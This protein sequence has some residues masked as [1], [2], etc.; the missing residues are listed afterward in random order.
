MKYFIYLIIA[1]PGIVNAQTL[2]KSIKANEGGVTDILYLK[3]KNQIISAGNDNRFHVWDFSSNTKIKSLAGHSK[4]TLVN[5][6]GDFLYTSGDSKVIQWNLKS[7]KPRKILNHGTE[8]S[9]MLIN[10]SNLSV[11][12]VGSNKAIVWNEEGKQITQLEINNNYSGFTYTSNSQNI[13]FYDGQSLVQMNVLSKVQKQIYSSSAPIIGVAEFNETYGI[14][15]AAKEVIFWSYSSEKIKIETEGNPEIIKF[16]PDGQYLFVGDDI[17]IMYIISVAEGILLNSMGV[18]SGA[19]TSIAF[20]ENN[21]IT[22]SLDAYIKI[23]DISFLN[24]LTKQPVAS[25]NTGPPPSIEVIQPKIIKANDVIDIDEPEYVIKGKVK[26]E[27]GIFLLLVRGFEVPINPDG[28][29]SHK[30][31]LHYFENDITVKAL[32]NNKNATEMSFIL[33]RPFK[34]ETRQYARRGSDY[35]LIIA[36]NDYDEITDLTN[37]IFDAGVI[38]DELTKNY[39]FNV[40]TLLNPTQI[41]LYTALRAYNKKIFSEHDQLFIFIAGHGEYDDVFQE[42]YLVTKDSRKSDDV[43]STYISHSNLRTIINNINCEHILLVMDVCFGGTFD[44]II[45]RRGGDDYNAIDKDE[46]IHRKLQYKTRLYVTSGGKEYVPDGR[47]GAHS[48]FARKFIEAL[49]NY[50]GSDQILTLNELSSYVEKVTPEPRKGEFGDN[51]PGSDFLF[52]KK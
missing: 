17:G 35:A 47:P 9:A 1:L 28:T 30:M 51:E 15:T 50:G 7:L 29:F 23:H 43:K 46:F 3:E 12:T 33:N 19:I 11:L 24:I 20:D 27:S 48:P 44:P 5:K 10:N 52:I 6:V 4:S 14:T 31:K 8:I 32:D 38:A 41:E 42:G 2:K 45:A 37:P 21:L 16:S 25:V 34:G 18:H 22:S 13:L 40:Q 36:T 26:A 49:R 39:G